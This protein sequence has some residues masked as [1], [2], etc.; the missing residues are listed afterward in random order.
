MKK[1]LIVLIIGSGIAFTAMTG[2]AEKAYVTNT[3][4]ITLRGGPDRERRIIA[5]VPVGQSVEVL[6]TREGWSHVRLLGPDGGGKMGW[7]VSG[8]LVTRVPWEIQAG[9][10]NRE[11]TQLKEKLANIEEKWR[12]A[13]RDSEESGG[14]LKTKTEALDR[15]EKE[16]DSLKREASTFLKLKKKYEVTRKGLQDAKTTS[17]RLLKENIALKSSQRNKWFLSGASVLLAGLIFG[18]IMGRTQRKRKSSYY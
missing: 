13:S 8:Y 15:I 14:K 6:E 4:K 11:N 17:E 12:K 5:M 2:W 10:L 18:L 16:Y 3:S 7:I 1:A 9:G